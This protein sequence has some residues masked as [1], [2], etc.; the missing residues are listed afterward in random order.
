MKYKE[1]NIHSIEPVTLFTIVE[2]NSQISEQYKKIRTN[3]MYGQ[4][5]AVKSFIVT[6]DGPGEG[7]STTAANLAISFSQLG[8][9]TILVD[10]DMRRPTVHLTFDLDNS[11][12]LSNLLSIK[13]LIVKDVIN[14][15]VLSKLDVLT[16]GTRV[17]NPSELL[18]NR[19]M[20]RLIVLLQKNYDIII[21]DMPPVSLVTDAQILAPNVDGVVI[22]VRENITQKNSLK[23]T[24]KLIERVGGN[25]LGAVY[26]SEQEKGKRNNYYYY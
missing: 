4:K 16:S 26:L 5:I 9:K 14:E 1:S 24:V 10:A 23:Q 3:I 6:S 19:R 2:P 17:M 7:K 20:K 21:F 8:F 11:F 13:N 12:G 25:I 22:V 18:S 15:N